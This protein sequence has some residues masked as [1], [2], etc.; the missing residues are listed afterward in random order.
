MMGTPGAPGTPGTPVELQLGA[1]HIQW[2]YIGDALWTDIIAIAD[3][4]GDDGAPG[5]PAVN[6][7]LQK[8]TAYSVAVCR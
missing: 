2:R 4:T 3:L 6:I 1:T 8:S 5:T 7:E